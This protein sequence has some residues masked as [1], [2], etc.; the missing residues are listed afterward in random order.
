VF[1]KFVLEVK[2]DTLVLFGLFLVTSVG[3]AVRFDVDHVTEALQAEAPLGIKHPTAEIEP[4]GPPVAL[5]VNG[6]S[7]PYPVLTPFVAYA[8]T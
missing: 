7:D 1:E 8:R 2:N 5:V 6:T 4:D 3:P